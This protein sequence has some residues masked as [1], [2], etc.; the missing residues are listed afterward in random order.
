MN[1]EKYR[2]FL[3]TYPP[4]LVNVV[5]ERPPSPIPHSPKNVFYAYLCVTLYS[6]Y[7]V[8]FTVEKIDGIHVSIHGMA[9][10]V[11]EFQLGGTNFLAN[12]E[13]VQMKFH[14]FFEMQ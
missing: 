14:I 2:H 6:F 1:V 4:P 8:A 10:S 3:T 11:V 5:Y 9:I 12:N 13:Q 7:F